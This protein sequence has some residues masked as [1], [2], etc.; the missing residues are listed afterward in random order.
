MDTASE[1]DLNNLLIHFKTDL[2]AYGDAK[3][4]ANMKEADKQC[5]LLQELDYVDS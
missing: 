4:V 3:L 2:A 5:K 1:E